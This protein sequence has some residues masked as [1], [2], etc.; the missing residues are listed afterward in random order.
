TRASRRQ[1]WDRVPVRART[2]RRTAVSVALVHG[3]G[4]VTR[5]DPHLVLAAVVADV[6]LPHDGT[7]MV[8]ELELGDVS[9]AFGKDFLGRLGVIQLGGVDAPL[10]LAAAF[11]TLVG[12]TRAALDAAAVGRYAEFGALAILRDDLD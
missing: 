12:L 6:G 5:V 7:V 2:A 8:V 1:N 11:G 4:A 3:H 10:P 9:R